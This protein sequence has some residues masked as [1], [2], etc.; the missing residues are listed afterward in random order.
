[1]L[2]QEEP[3][4]WDEVFASHT[5]HEIQMYYPM[6]VVRDRNYKLIWNI[7]HGL[8]YPFATDLWVSA[9]WQEVYQQG[10]DQVYGVKRIQDYI[11]RP[12]F[13]LYDM[14]SDPF[15]STNLA[16]NPQFEDVLS[17]YKEKMKAFQTR[18]SDPW[19]M[20]WYYQ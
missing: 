8:P 1:M 6:R 15:E 7:A 9:T 13:E 5:F 19:A 2:E 11:Y 18:T 12:E 10:T 4:G 16:G 20:K 17:A 3:A 14:K